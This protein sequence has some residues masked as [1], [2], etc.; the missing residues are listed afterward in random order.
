M[1]TNNGN[2]KSD[3]NHFSIEI[4]G[5]IIGIDAISTGI[6]GYCIRYLTD[7]SPV[8]RVGITEEELHKEILKNKKYRKV[9]NEV[10]LESIGIYR[11]IAEYALSHDVLLMHGAV[12]AHK[13]DAFMF[14]ASSGTGKTTHIRQWLLNDKEAYVV[15]GDKPLIRINS[16]EAF[17]C[18]SPW[19]GKE[20]MGTNATVRLNAII[21]LERSNENHIEEIPFKAAYPYLLEYSHRPEDIAKMKK[22]IDL[23]MRLNGKVRFFKFYINNFKKDCFPMAYN[24]LIQTVENAV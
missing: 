8:V 6:Y 23:L 19:N 15:N 2:A 1:G 22:T 12:I 3:M 18:G 10:Y 4:A 21:I 17:A 20:E 7:K 5:L 13:K 16:K 24:K 14:V 9:P 11:K